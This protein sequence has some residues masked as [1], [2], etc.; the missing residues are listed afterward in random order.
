MK[1]FLSLLI[2]VSMVFAFAGCSDSNES[3]N[4]TELQT[5]ETTQQEESKQSEE[6]NELSQSFDKDK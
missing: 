5:E 3:N 4:Q 2:A 1:K 6:Q